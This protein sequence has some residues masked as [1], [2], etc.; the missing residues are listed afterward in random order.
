MKEI[1]KIKLEELNII[2]VIDMCKSD[3]KYLE[4][5]NNH[6][7]T[8]FQAFMSMDNKLFDL[9][10]YIIYKDRLRDRITGHDLGK[11]YYPR[12]FAAYRY[13]YYPNK[14]DPF[15]QEQID[16]WYNLANQYH[17]TNNRHHYECS[18]VECI[19]N[20]N[21]NE[22]GYTKK[23]NIL[24]TLEMLCDWETFNIREPETGNTLD[25]WNANKDKINEEYP[26]LL[27]IELIDKVLGKMYSAGGYLI[28]GE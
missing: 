3:L 2:P 12:I 13:K 8:L 11:F 27:N 7:K 20:G 26:N 15:T 28:G 6:R 21:I 9:D 22:N 19:E 24:D 14:L 18:A 4:H 23:M 25:W 5:I 17:K 10:E 1:R 16:E